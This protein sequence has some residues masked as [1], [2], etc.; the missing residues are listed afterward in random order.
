MSEEHTP[1]EDSWLDFSGN[2]LKAEMVEEWPVKL[3]VVSIKTEFDKDQKAR[4]FINTEYADRKWKLEINKTNQ[5][6]LKS[7]KIE[8]P[9]Q[10]VGKILTFDKTMVRNPS[11]NTQVPSFLLI[12]VE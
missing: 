7:N 5:K 8:S 6:T 4:L 3:P 10:T 9:S 11:T 1:N 2:F 12:E